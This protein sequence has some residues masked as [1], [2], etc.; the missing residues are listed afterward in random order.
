MAATSVGAIYGRR[1]SQ[2]YGYPIHGALYQSLHSSGNCP[3]AHL[4]KYTVP[5][6]GIHVPDSTGVCIAYD[7]VVI[8]NAHLHYYIVAAG[9]PVTNL[10][11]TFNWLYICS[12]M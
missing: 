11:P 12:Q 7:Q 2:F 4:K 5:S 6:F 9:V 3:L 1:C 10:N 8:M